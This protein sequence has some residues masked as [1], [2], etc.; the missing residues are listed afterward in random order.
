MPSVTI[1]LTDQEQ[2]WLEAQAESGRFRN[3]T[4][5]LRDLIQRDRERAIKIAALQK[6]VDEAFSSGVSDRSLDEIWA[7]AR[8]KATAGDGNPV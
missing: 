8:R 3:S 1:S 2:E 5:Y 4:D 6:K 7:E